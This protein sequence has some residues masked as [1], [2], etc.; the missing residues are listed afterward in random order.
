MAHETPDERLT[1]LRMTASIGG[2]TY[3][4][5]VDADRKASHLEK[6]NAGRMAKYL[7]QVDEIGT[8]PADERMRRAL[9]LRKADMQRLAIK[10][11]RVR[12][13][14]RVDRALRRQDALADQAEEG[15]A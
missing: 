3:W 2:S 4:A 9:A 7:A 8:F 15:A 11:A 1:R 10:S 13:A 5:T 14:G 6:L 12:R